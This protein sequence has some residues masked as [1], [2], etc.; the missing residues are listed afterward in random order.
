MGRSRDFKRFLD[1]A[2]VIVS[3]PAYRPNARFVLIVSNSQPCFFRVIMILYDG[4]LIILIYRR[5]VG[6]I[7]SVCGV[8]QW[9][10]AEPQTTANQ[11]TGTSAHCAADCRH[12]A[13]PMPCCRQQFPDYRYS[14]LLSLLGRVSTLCRYEY[15]LTCIHSNNL[16]FMRAF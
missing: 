15:A 4:V 11:H 13:I 5:Q 8:D 7:W 1:P 9:P 12:C 10:A 6:G 2:K 3:C 16:Y 14:F